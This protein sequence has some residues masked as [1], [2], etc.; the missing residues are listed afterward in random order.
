MRRSHSLRVL[1][2]FATVAASAVL[3]ASASASIAPTLTLTQT[4]TGFGT[5]AGSSTKLGLDLNSHA[6]SDAF[7]S[8]TLT[9]PPGLLADAAIN[10][11]RCL[12][13]ATPSAACQVGSGTIS[14]ATGSSP[15]PVNVDL[16][17]PPTTGDVAGLAVVAQSAP[18]VALDTAG[19]VVRSGTDPAGVGLNLVFT[20]LTGVTD[21]NATLNVR[22]PDSCPATPAN[23][24][25]SAKA[26]SAPTGAAQ[27]ATA[28]LTVTGCGG[29]AYAPTFAVA[30]SADSSHNATVTATITQAAGEATTKS[31]AL[32]VP[33]NLAPNLSAPP[34]L[35][36]SDAT[37]ATCKPVGT[38][39]ATSPLLPAASN[40]SVYLT[41]SLY[42]PVLTIALPSPLSIRLNGAISLS[43][44]SV[45][46]ASVPDVPL[47]KLAVTFGGSTNAVFKTTCNPASDS[48]TAAF[49][50]QNGDKTL[51]RTAT[52][53]VTGCG[54]APTGPTTPTTKPGKPTV[55]S[56]SL[57]GL[58]H[59]RAS[60]RF[61]LSAGKNAPKL[62]SFSIKLPGGLSFVKAKLQQGLSLGG[63]TI[64]SEKLSG[65]T[66]TVT[67]KSAATGFTVKLSSSAVRVSSKLSKSV[68]KKQKKNLK[69]R[70]STTDVNHKSS[71]LTLTFK[72]L[73]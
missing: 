47:T 38:A 39:S 40:G 7:S 52:F 12:T 34:T 49:T 10:S 11:G 13:A 19:V 41:G 25:V 69:V 28:P 44:N 50:D 56:S 4:G 18:T 58:G 73:G 60:L 46:F 20:N 29:L 36:C 70:V 57:S 33:S 8:A 5:A 17:K 54:G 30:A 66:L 51:S 2:I 67:L 16:V 32:K 53:S 71:S 22:M 37:L 62:G 72:K 45:T 68:R 24:A 14:T 15:I 3:A 42:A 55:G 61:R 64:K 65:G 35:I 23:V 63:A 31:L 21:I 27:T 26:V 59:G 1:V 9:L 48:A 6:T 43:N